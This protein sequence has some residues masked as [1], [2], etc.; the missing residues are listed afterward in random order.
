M[1]QKSFGTH[2]L[3]FY[4][5]RLKLESRFLLNMP[6][7]YTSSLTLSRQDQFSAIL[8]LLTPDDLASQEDT[9]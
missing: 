4:T 1:L 6:H 3:E 8:L 7:V 2:Q 9:C 5:M